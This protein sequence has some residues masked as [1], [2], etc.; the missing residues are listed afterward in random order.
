VAVNGY[1][2]AAVLS[3]W[4]L[5]IVIAVAQ[6]GLLRK[7]APLLDGGHRHGPVVPQGLAA[8]QPVGEFEAVGD[9]GEVVGREAL[10]GRPVLV[11]LS[12]AGCQPCEQLAAELRSAEP[13]PPG[14]LVVITT[15][16]G[17]P[18]LP[19]W[20]TV[21]RQRGT[22]AAAAFGTTATPHAF[23]LDAAGVV[24]ARAIPASLAQLRD[25]L[26]P[27]NGRLPPIPTRQRKDVQHR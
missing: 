5:L 17:R 27:G 22:S 13:W 25:V 9:G 16:D 15:G 21:L 3:L 14:S 8:G 24:T 6:L 20:V 11:L 26:L 4:L 10:L 12:S 1:W 2:I 18:D 7:V 23:A 19:A